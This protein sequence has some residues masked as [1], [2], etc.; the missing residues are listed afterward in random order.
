M[1]LMKKINPTRYSSAVGEVWVMT[2]FKIKYCHKIFDFRAVSEFCLA[3]FN[4]AFLFYGIA[5]KKIAF[6]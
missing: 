4:Q 2:I 5:C 3:V 1:I 6:D